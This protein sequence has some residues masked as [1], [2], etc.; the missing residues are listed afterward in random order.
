MAVTPTGSRPS[1]RISS[2][3]GLCCKQRLRGQHV[4]DFAGADAEGQGPEGPVRGRVAVAADD[5]HARLGEPQLR[6]DH[7][8]DALVAVVEVV[9]ADAELAAVLPQGVDLLLGDRVGDRQAAVGGGHVVVDRGHGPLGPPDLAAGQPQPLEGLGAGHFVDQVQVD[10]QDRLLAFFGM[11]DV[12][13]PDLLE[14][15]PGV[16]SHIGADVLI[17]GRKRRTPP[18]DY[19]LEG[20]LE[21]LERLI[22][23]PS[24][25]YTLYTAAADVSSGP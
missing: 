24:S 13:V 8:D 25:I 1:T 18:V 19:P 7:V 11:D 17:A 4:L 23:K 22:L 12:V 15:R 16:G 21:I 5:R 20:I 9:E 3:L 2:V 6:P 14:H 10:V